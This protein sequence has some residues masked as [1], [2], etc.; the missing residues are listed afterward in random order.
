MSC[1][2]RPKL[3]ARASENKTFQNSS[4][5]H[6][7]QSSPSLS[8]INDVVVVVVIVVVVVVIN[9]VIV[10]AIA[11]TGTMSRVQVLQSQNGSNVTEIQEYNRK[12]S[13]QYSIVL[14]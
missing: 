2:D 7:N 9:V 12:N 11:I 5:L 8:K 3:S 4:F 10:V 14:F 13:V 1:L 6:E